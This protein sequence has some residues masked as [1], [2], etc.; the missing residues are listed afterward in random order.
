MPFK[1]KKKNNKARE[2]ALLF[3][4]AKGMAYLLAH[5]TLIT[6]GMKIKAILIYFLPKAA[7]ILMF[8]SSGVIDVNPYCVQVFTTSSMKSNYLRIRHG[9]VEKRPN[10]LPNGPYFPLFV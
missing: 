9:R 4:S 1:K 10:L 6:K 8:S 3:V 7:E 5:S 2:Q